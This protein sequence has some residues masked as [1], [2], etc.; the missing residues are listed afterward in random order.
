MTVTLRIALI[1]VMLIAVP[2]MAN[3]DTSTVNPNIQKLIDGFQGLW[4]DLKTRII[5]KYKELANFQAQTKEVMVHIFVHIRIDYVRKCA[6]FFLFFQEV[7]QKMNDTLEYLATIKKHEAALVEEAKNTSV[8]GYNDATKKLDE[9]IA[10][11][12]QKQTEVRLWNYRHYIVAHC[13]YS[14]TLPSL[15]CCH[16]V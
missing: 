9:W 12:K 6:C 13:L 2:C 3:E 14:M 11:V 16:T 5:S 8:A 15:R 10:D 4:S 7:S 1:F